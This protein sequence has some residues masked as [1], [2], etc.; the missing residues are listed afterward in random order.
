ML[1]GNLLMRAA[2]V[3][4]ACQRCVRAYGQRVPSGVPD[5][6]VLLLPLLP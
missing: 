4:P 3:V 5:P 1:L 6:L 2:Y